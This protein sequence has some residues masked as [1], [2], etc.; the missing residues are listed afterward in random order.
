[1]TLLFVPLST[2]GRHACFLVIYYPFIEYL[3]YLPD[4]LLFYFEQK[5]RVRVDMLVLYTFARTVAEKYVYTCLYVTSASFSDGVFRR[6]GAACLRNM[7]LCLL[8]R[9]SLCLVLLSTSVP[10]FNVS[11]TVFYM[12]I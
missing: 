10:L 9:C 5:R 6:D 2:S 8:D 12:S 1:M 3:Q 4:E 7:Q 11:N